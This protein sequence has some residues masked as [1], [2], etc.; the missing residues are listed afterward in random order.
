MTFYSR[1]SPIFVPV[2]N[3]AFAKRPDNK[4]TCRA[5]VKTETR[6]G[7]NSATGNL[8]PALQER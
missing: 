2:L 1:I 6:Q 8:F 3:P 7:Q 5:S 4:K